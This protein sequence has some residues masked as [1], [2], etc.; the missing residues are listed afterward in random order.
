M[1][2][3]LLIMICL[4]MAVGLF[5]C[6][7][8]EDEVE[9]SG[10]EQ[11]VEMLNTFF[12]KTLTDPAFIATTICY[13]QILTVETVNKTTACLENK[14]THQTIYTFIK[15]SEYYTAVVETKYYGVGKGYYDNN[16][17]M[18]M[19]NV[20]DAKTIKDATY[21]CKVSSTAKD[22]VTSSEL[23]YEVDS[24]T[25]VIQITASATDGLVNSFTYGAVNKENNTSFTKTVSFVYGE[26]NINIP[27]LEDYQLSGE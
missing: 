16:Y 5:G 23:V 27:D 13:G 22:G 24:A 3:L 2:K 1:K 25:K 14:S 18:F 10:Q 15:D 8:V 12:Q 6:G 19:N 17:C 21:T 26:I 7:E 20:N 11:S 9:V 4:L